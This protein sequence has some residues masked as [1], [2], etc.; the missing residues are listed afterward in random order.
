MSNDPFAKQ[1]EDAARARNV[2]DPETEA[3]IPVRDETDEY[4]PAAGAAPVPKPTPDLR[5]L[6]APQE[7]DE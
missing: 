1:N 6:A 2:A 3:P 7:P 5:F 4:G